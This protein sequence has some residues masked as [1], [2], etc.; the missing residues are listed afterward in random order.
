MIQDKVI[1]LL[2]Y[3]I[4]GLKQQLRDQDR[5]ITDLQALIKKQEELIKEFNDVLRMPKFS[6]GSIVSII[7]MKGR[8]KIEHYI[9]DIVYP[10]YNLSN[11]SNP[12]QI[13]T[14]PEVDIVEDDD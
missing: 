13:Q 14:V 7:G 12:N 11:I 3:R 9:Y 2:Q 5:T 6:N 4:D 8:Y 1:K 10:I